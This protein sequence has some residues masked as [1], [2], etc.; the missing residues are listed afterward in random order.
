MFYGSIAKK[1]ELQIVGIDNTSFK[2][3][4]KAVEGVVLVIVN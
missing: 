1:E 3:N 4:E 2:T